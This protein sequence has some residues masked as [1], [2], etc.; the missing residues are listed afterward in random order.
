MRKNDKS[1][2]EWTNNLKLILYNF[3]INAII[4]VL[5]CIIALFSDP[6]SELYYPFALVGLCLGNFISGFLNG[7]IKR[8]KGIING[9]IYSLP[10]TFLIML[11][12]LILNEF[13]VG[14]RMPVSILLICI[15][16]A[17][18]G[19]LAVNAKKKVKVKRK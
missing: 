3:I 13:S 7:R 1:G 2:K 11:I 16:S 17:I 18:G 10:V 12:S 5:L 8:R 9:L 15:C 19:I 6:D 4:F 14:I